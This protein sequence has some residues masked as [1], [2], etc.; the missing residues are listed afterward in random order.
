[1]H[2]G[3]PLLHGRVYIGAAA[4]FVGTVVE[5]REPGYLRGRFGLKLADGR[6]GGHDAVTGVGSAVRSNVIRTESVARHESGL[7]AR[8]GGRLDF[9]LQIAAWKEAVLEKLFF[10]DG[11]SRG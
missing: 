7:I 9:S 6:R 1:M 8:V 11:I 3:C 10:S 2:V 4:D 5:Q